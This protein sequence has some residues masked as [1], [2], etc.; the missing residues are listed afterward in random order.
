MLKETGNQHLLELPTLDSPGLIFQL[1][2]L[3]FAI[4]AQA[5]KFVYFLKYFL[6]R[7]TKYVITATPQESQHINS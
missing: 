4:L 2:C 5:T 3:W 1:A 6:L 7:V